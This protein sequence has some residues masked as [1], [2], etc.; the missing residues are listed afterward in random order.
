MRTTIA[1][2]KISALILIISV[3]ITIILFYIIT[4]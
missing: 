1:G 4:F 2:S 3:I